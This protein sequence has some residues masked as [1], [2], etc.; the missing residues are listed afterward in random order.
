LYAVL[1]Q[2]TENDIRI[3][4][5]MGMVKKFSYLHGGIVYE[6]GFSQYNED[7]LR[8]QT[9]FDWLVPVAQEIIYKY[10]PTSFDF[11]T[12]YKKNPYDKKHIYECIIEYIDSL[13][14]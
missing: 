2:S 4:L 11:D 6:R 10:P 12:E 7:E 14:I 9:S 13:K 3:A 8:Y 1:K 5:F